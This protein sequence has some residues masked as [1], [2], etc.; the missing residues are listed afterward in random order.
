MFGSARLKKSHSLALSAIDFLFAFLEPRWGGIIVFYPFVMTC[1]K[2]KD[3]SGTGLPLVSAYALRSLVFIDREKEAGKFEKKKRKPAG[4][5]DPHSQS[6]A[7]PCSVCIKR[8]ASRQQQ[9][10]HHHYHRERFN[11]GIR[12]AQEQHYC[13]PFLSLV[14]TD[15]ANTVTSTSSWF[16][17]IEFAQGWRK[18]KKEG[19]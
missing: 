9:H 6:I 2:E 17:P 12:A 3:Q 1:R 10:R 5:E 4:I 18:N 8:L 7:A 19:Q 15:A 16:P 11:G 13:W 14:L